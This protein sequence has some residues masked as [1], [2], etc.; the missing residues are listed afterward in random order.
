MFVVIQLIRR[1][2]EASF[3]GC[4]QGQRVRIRKTEQFL[5]IFMRNKPLE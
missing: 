1:K 2:Q 5:Y 3:I 4:A